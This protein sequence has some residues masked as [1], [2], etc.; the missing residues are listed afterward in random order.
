MSRGF[1]ISATMG[2]SYHWAKS[3]WGGLIG[4]KPTQRRWLERARGLLLSSRRLV[5][6]L[7]TAKLSHRHLST[8]LVG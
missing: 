5:E 3:F 7:D 6:L 1:F 8:L 2:I 4:R